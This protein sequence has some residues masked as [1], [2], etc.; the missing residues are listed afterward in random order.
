ME[1]SRVLG[2]DSGMHAMWDRAHFSEIRDYPSW[3]RELLEDDDIERHI[4]AGHLVP[5]NIG[6]DGAFHITV[7]AE[8]ASMPALEEHEQAR[9]L[10]QSEPYR[11]QSL[12]HVDVSGIE[13][14]GE[15]PDVRTVAS[16]DFAAGDYE[17]RVHLLDWDDRPVSERGPDFIVLVGPP[18]TGPFRRTVR[19]F[20]RPAT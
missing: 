10:V 3:E 5:I 1:F 12:G 2:T 7:R 19:T 13:H 18:S 9:V 17:A 11:F 4:A 16:L 20:E 15:D 14:V 6:H 8:R